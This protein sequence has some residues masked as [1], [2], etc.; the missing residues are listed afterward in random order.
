MQAV[1]EWTERYADKTMS[2]RDALLQIRSGSRVFLSPGC[3]EPQHLLNELVDLGGAAG[4]LN[5]VEIVHM[6]TIGSAPHARKR[7]DRHFRHN[8]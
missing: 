1:K 5:D 7:Y 6:L 2:A 3:G 8:S 4:R